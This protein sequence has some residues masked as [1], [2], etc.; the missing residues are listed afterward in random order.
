MPAL[1]F[2]L[3]DADQI[4]RRFSGID[5]SVASSEE[6]ADYAPASKSED[7]SSLEDGSGSERGSE[8]GTSGIIKLE[9]GT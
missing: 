1:A 4:G 5:R 2:D 8:T 9:P 7:S 6:E 3:T